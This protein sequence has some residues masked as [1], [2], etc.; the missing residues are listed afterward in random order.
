[1]ST[2]RAPKRQRGDTCLEGGVPGAE[3]RGQSGPSGRVVDRRAPARS[4][5]LRQRVLLE[6]RG[7]LEVDRMEPRAMEARRIVQEI[8]EESTELRRQ[9][10][11]IRARGRRREGR[12]PSHTMHRR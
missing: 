8:A 1:M 5:A 10:G 9:R 11:E 3:G 6:E 7:D 2:W 12:R 4:G